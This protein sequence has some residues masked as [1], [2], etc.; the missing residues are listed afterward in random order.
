MLIRRM[1]KWDYDAVDRLL[2]QLQQADARSRPDMFAPMAHYMPRESFDCLL[3]NDNVVAF[4][5]QERLDIVAC[6][7]VSLLDSSSAHPVKIAYIDLLVVDAALHRDHPRAAAL[8][9]R[10]I[11]RQRPLRHS[12]DGSLDAEHRPL[13]DAQRT[14]RDLGEKLLDRL[15]AAA[16]EESHV[17]GVDPH[18]RHGR[19]AQQAD[20]VEQRTVAAVADHD[21]P[22]A[23]G[24]TSVA[25]VLLFGGNLRYAQRTDRFGKLFVY[26]EVESV[27][28]DRGERASQFVGRVDDAP[29][30]KKQ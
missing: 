16:G 28:G 5:A 10:F 4:V 21:R 14:A 11:D 2:L 19:S 20:A 9:G 25:A 26:N 18:H 22:V 15:L 17:A 30:G 24:G 7:F 13:F 29:A 8:H 6:C 3:E 23:D 12:F 1:T 27:T